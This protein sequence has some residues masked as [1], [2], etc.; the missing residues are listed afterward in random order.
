M[1]AKTIWFLVGA[2]A[3]LPYIALM[4]FYPYVRVGGFS[5]VFSF[6]MLFLPPALIFG[7]ILS[8][9]L[10]SGEGKYNPKV[11]IRILFA[12]NLI[13]YCVLFYSIFINV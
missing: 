11:L 4:I 2:L 1:T 10:D 7:V 6:L 8:F 13:F 3:V 5:S 12:A 9:L